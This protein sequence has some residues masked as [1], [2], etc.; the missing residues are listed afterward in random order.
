MAIKRMLENKVHL[1]DVSYVSKW[2]WAKGDRIYLRKM[3]SSEA[4]R[5]MS[6]EDLTK[7][8]LRERAISS[9]D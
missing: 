9:T 6:L 5:L 8:R 1:L 7:L 2:C 3:D 4:I